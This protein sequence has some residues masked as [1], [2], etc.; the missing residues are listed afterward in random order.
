M[1]LLHDQ[2]II[3]GHTLDHD[4]L[5]YFLNFT[6]EHTKYCHIDLVCTI[7]P[8]LFVLDQQKRSVVLNSV[9]VIYLN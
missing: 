2:D 8:L 9:L 3:H 1:Q 5:H 6:Y 4:H 7:A